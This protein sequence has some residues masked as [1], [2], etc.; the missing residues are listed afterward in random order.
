[1][2]KYTTPQAKYSGK[3]TLLKMKAVAIAKVSLYKTMRLPP[4][5]QAC[6]RQNGQYERLPGS[7][8]SKTAGTGEVHDGPKNH[9]RYV[10]GFQR[11]PKKRP[12]RLRFLAGPKK[13]ANTFTVFGT[14]PT[15]SINVLAG[16]LGPL[17]TIHV[18]TFF[19]RAAKNYKRTG[20]S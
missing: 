11:G 8:R 20:C 12:I 5:V 15:P 6:P 1:M 9:G 10:Y 16:F 14:S 7:P 3:S 17:R 19:L 2:V 13:T 4:K 18:L